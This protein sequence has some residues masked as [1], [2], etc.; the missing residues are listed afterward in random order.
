MASFSQIYAL[1]SLSNFLVSFERIAP[2][3]ISSTARLVN[4]LV[5][6]GWFAPDSQPHP[7]DFAPLSTV[8]SG[9]EGDKHQKLRQWPPTHSAKAGHFSFERTRTLTAN[10]GCF[11]KEK[12]TRNIAKSVGGS[13]A[14]CHQLCCGAWKLGCSSCAA[15]HRRCQKLSSSFETRRMRQGEAVGGCHTG[16]SS[17]G[18]GSSCE[19]YPWLI[20]F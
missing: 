14:E 1:V 6:F 15:C 3:K 4:S 20:L 13:G 16:V 8:L 19:P 5:S 18:L 11:A 10:C 12:A 7:F 2:S 9:G 17:L